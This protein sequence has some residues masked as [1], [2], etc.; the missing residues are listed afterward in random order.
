MHRFASP[1]EPEEGGLEGPVL[2]TLK[3]PDHTGVLLIPPEHHLQSEMFPRKQ[4]ELSR[5][6]NTAFHICQEA[7]ESVA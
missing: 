5:V 2:V 1:G 4:E 7:L 3:P 6:R